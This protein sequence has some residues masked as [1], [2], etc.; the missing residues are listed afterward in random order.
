M[1]ETWV[2]WE[3]SSKRPRFFFRRKIPAGLL[4]QLC[5]PLQ[6]LKLLKAL[7]CW[8]LE[9]T[10]FKPTNQVAACAL[11]LH[12]YTQN[13]QVKLY[14]GKTN[15]FIK[16]KKSNIYKKI[17][18]IKSVFTISIDQWK[19]MAFLFGFVLSLRLYLKNGEP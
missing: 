6:L 7:G 3:V 5:T 17:Y 10:A 16:N 4:T 8:H 11:S 9:I 13:K 14:I 15:A 1:Y 12:I 2:N 18:Q 19:W